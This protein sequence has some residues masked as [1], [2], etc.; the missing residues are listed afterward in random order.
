L[1]AMMKAFYSDTFVLPL[2]P[3]HRFPMLK[4]SMLRDRVLSE[5]IIPP[6]DLYVAQP[7]TDEQLLRAHDAEYVEK[8]KMGTLSRQEQRRIGFP[9]SPQLALRSRCTVGATINACRAALEMAAEHG[10]GVSVN[11]AGGTH[12]AYRDHG[13]GYCVF[14]DSAVAART[15]QAE[16]RAR[17]IVIIDC[18]VHQ[19]NG[20]AA[21]LAGDSTVFTFSAHGE[22]NFPFYKERSD[23]DIELPDHTTDAA[24]LEAVEEGTR[25]A[26]AMAGADLALYLAGADP[27]EHDRLGRMKVS[28]AGLAKRDQIVLNLCR[29]AGLPVAIVM[30]GGYAPNVEEIVAIHLQTIRIAA[31]LARC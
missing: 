15:M 8:V 5:G 26:I 6:E 14:N 23:L 9:W 28:M 24:Y 25:R 19:G 21:I 12:H 20:T 3:E 16:E 7:A 31:E 2:P 27:Y 4:Y 22:K 18:D 13:Q 17:R 30:A 29:D 10:F 11:L 1:R